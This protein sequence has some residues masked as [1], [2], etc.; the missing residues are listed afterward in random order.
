MSGSNATLRVSIEAALGTFREDLGRAS[1]VAETNAKRIDKA[2]GDTKAQVAGAFRGIAGALGIS[3]GVDA[4]IGAIRSIHDAAADEQR[5]LAQL[6]ATLKATGSAA[7]LT[8]EQL[9]K[10]G[11]DVKF[12]TTF[13]D[14]DVRKAETA[15][16]RFR[17]VQGSVFQ[18]AIRLA[19][20]VA[21]ALGTDLT[22]AATALGKAL[23]DPEHGMRALKDAGI[24][25]SDQ[26]KDLAA[27]MIEAGDKA[28][29][30]RIIMG[31]LS[32]SIGGLSEADNSGAYG[33][34][35][36]LA[37][38]WGDLQKT[39]GR[40]L[41]A[42]SGG[43]DKLTEFLER[44][45]RIISLPPPTSSA[46]TFQR[47]AAI[48]GL[49][50]EPF[51]PTEPK[52]DSTD[53]GLLVA[54]GR[55]AAI[56]KLVSNSKE[57]RNADYNAQQAALK[58]EAEAASSFY[59]AQLGAQRAY[60][61][62]QLQADDFAYS[63]G[64]LTIDEFYSKQITAINANELATVQANEAEIQA[65]KRLAAALGSNTEARAA[66]EAKI[67]T[68]QAQS[69]QSRNVFDA[70]QTQADQQRQLAVE[71]LGDEYSTLA[72]KVQL[73]LGNT[74]A[75]AQI[76][77]DRAD[78]DLR[79][80][81]EHTR[82]TGNP[83]ESAGAQAMLDDQAMLAKSAT[84]QGD[85]T[86]ATRK[87][88]N[89]IADL[90][91]AQS[92]LDIQSQT[93][94][95]SEID[96]LTKKADIAKQYIPLLQEEI[97]AQQKIANDL[98]AGVVK[99][100]TLQK[101]AQEKLQIEQLGLAADGLKNKFDGIV[102][103]NFTTALDAIVGRTKSAKDAFKDMGKSIEQSITHMVDEQL[104]KT[105][106]NALFGA[107]GATG[108]VSP[109]GLL[110]GLFGSAGAGAAAAGAGGGAGGLSSLI[111]AGSP[112]AGL[113]AWLGMG[114]SSSSGLAGLLGSSW[115][116]GGGDVP[117]LDAF[118]S[119]G[120]A[121]DAAELGDP[122]A[123]LLSGLPYL[124]SGTDNWSGGLA[125]VGEKGPELVN[126]PRGAQVIPNKSLSSMGGGG[127]T[128]ITIHNNVMP[129]ASRA[130]AD[131]SAAQIG[132]QLAAASRRRNAG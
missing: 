121:G 22:T 39:L 132:R 89:T 65:Q 120:I 14:D 128:Y 124:A 85:L 101:I 103:D 21:T 43:L 64:A 82:D 97:D 20:D 45:Q 92:H 25:L 46:E 81:L 7:G 76:S 61:D 60:L 49:A 78:R 106:F 126:L 70:K 99:T 77:T 30:Q 83:Q 55:E 127:H 69:L 5:S 3:F 115:T 32:Q 62:K 95:M 131:H 47:S 129:G 86:D 53:D 122:T 125:M 59:G 90:G 112:L 8:A 1:A 93:G 105:L 123:T 9:E 6:Q 116:Y 11:G 114:S 79:R 52:K 24:S 80:R 19:P 16:L 41:V 72:E 12:K 34:T 84:L 118:Q 23:T 58:K 28:G 4:I 117:L 68:L 111:A 2:F 18:D 50:D 44:Y 104:A 108:G 40:P 130:T 42:N 107:G 113:A 10:L 13:D 73:A 17:D 96:L 87:Y 33:A 75:A 66:A 63:R 29:A 71:K 26:Q 94:L 109:G 56:G 51:S 110:A 48:F 67:A 54:R 57:A 31:E 91:V 36:R 100:E 27:R 98:P 102:V 35:K 15:L 74:G 37:R 88:S 119:A 38:A